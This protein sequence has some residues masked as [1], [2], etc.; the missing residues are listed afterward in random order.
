MKVVD[1]SMASNLLA[2]AS[3]LRAMGSK[4][5]MF[6]MSSYV[7]LDRC[8]VFAAVPWLPNGIGPLLGVNC[9]G[10]RR[11]KT[12]GSFLKRS[13]ALRTPHG[14]WMFDVSGCGSRPLHQVDLP[15]L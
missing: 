9:A 14:A 13:K 7:E 4:L 5:H 8:H 11:S 10:R 3:N 6:Q 2:M 1:A 12:Y 15:G